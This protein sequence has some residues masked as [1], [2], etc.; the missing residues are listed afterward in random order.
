M[1]S[2]GHST[3]LSSYNL[4]DRDYLIRTIAFEAAH[5]PALGKA[6]VAHVI[7]NR[8]KSGGW[9]STVKEIVTQPWQFEPW[10]TIRS[11]N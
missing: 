9:G 4:E 2:R 3:A 10:M 1:F 6:A 8:K 11:S 5:E 7:L